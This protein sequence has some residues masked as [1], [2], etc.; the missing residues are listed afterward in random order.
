MSWQLGEE[1]SGASVL[2]QEGPHTHKRGEKVETE[3]GASAVHG[4]RQASFRNA[5]GSFGKLLLESGRDSWRHT[6]G[7]DC[8]IHGC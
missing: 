8:Y 1:S 4:Y 6:C 3:S 7:S 5:C 2:R